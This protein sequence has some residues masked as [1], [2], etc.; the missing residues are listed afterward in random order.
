MSQNHTGGE[1]M[2]VLRT[3][4]SVNKAERADDG[5]SDDNVF[6]VANDPSGVDPEG[7]VDY[8]AHSSLKDSFLINPKKDLTDI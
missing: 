6:T 7:S 4:G 5:I 2:N 3:D 8:K 1:F